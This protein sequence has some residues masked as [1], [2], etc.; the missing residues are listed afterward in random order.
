MSLVKDIY[1][2]FDSRFA[3]F[4]S[5]QNSVINYILLLPSSGGADSGRKNT[6]KGEKILIDSLRGESP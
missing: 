5:L 3:R 6:A 1:I 4:T 2:A